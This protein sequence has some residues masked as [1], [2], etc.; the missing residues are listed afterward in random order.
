MYITDNDSRPLVNYANAMKELAESRGLAY[1]DLNAIFN[2]NY[3]KSNPEN[4]LAD[5]CHPNDAGYNEIAK[6]MI[7][8][9]FGI[10]ME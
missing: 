10:E 8:C 4:W 9:I 6:E 5:N 2:E 3:A 7:R 1:I